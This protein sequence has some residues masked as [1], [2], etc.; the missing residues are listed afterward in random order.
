MFTLPK[1]YSRDRYVKDMTFP[2]ES[3]VHWRHTVMNYT[4]LF[5]WVRGTGVGVYHSVIREWSAGNSHCTTRILFIKIGISWRT[6]RPFTTHFIYPSLA[7]RDSRYCQIGVLNSNVNDQHLTSTLWEL[8]RCPARAHSTHC[9][10]RQNRE[11]HAI[12]KDCR[13]WNSLIRLLMNSTNCT[14]RPD[15]VGSITVSEKDRFAEIKDR[16]RELL[17]FQI[18]NFRY[19]FPFGRPEGSLKVHHFY[20]LSSVIY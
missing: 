15:G 1:Q 20:L 5:L 12:A 16:L 8:Y 18:T 13:P 11:T 10:F 6:G 7:A 19:A 2:R 3:C 4:E 14:S 9:K 17:Q